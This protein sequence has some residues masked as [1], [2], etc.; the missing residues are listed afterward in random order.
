[1]LHISLLEVLVIH[2][3]M[4]LSTVLSE[5]SLH[6]SLTI[7]GA[8]LGAILADRFGRK[9][10]SFGAIIFVIPRALGIVFNE[11]SVN[12]MLQLFSK[13]NFG[14]TSTLV[15]LYIAEIADT[16]NRKYL[17]TL[18]MPFQYSISIISMAVMIT[19]ENSPR[20]RTLAIL[21]GLVLAIS[22][23]FY[24]ITIVFL[25]ESPDYLY[26]KKKNFKAT[27]SL[28]FFRRVNN[29]RIHEE[30]IELSSLD[31]QQSNVNQHGRFRRIRE[32][33][34]FVNRRSLAIIVSL[35][36]IGW[37]S[38]RIRNRIMYTYLAS[39]IFGDY[40]FAIL[41]G[42]WVVDL[43][44]S[45]FVTLGINA[46]S[47]KLFLLLVLSVNLIAAIIGM[48]NFM[49]YSYVLFGVFLI[50]SV[51]YLFIYGVTQ[52][53]MGEFFPTNIRAFA[54]ATVISCEI[55]TSNI[56]LTIDQYQLGEYLTLE[57]IRLFS[58]INGVIYFCAFLFV[59][60]FF[61]NITQLPS[62]QITVVT[63]TDI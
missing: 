44:F 62:S 8:F 48:L 63:S 58:Y 24:F 47:S 57:Y 56:F 50:H 18:R 9:K 1:M 3:R 10:A 22:V 38:G 34:Q 17:M 33:F 12:R 4:E 61:P 53:Y 32:M 20:E 31:V 29:I 27:K 59:L 30:A 5:F 28:A 45:I 2:S 49:Q 43:I 13:I 37:A 42:I 40:M 21:S 55:L 26:S 16:K 41:L 25:P 54:I 23:L 15:P 46:F 39:L 51:S 52:A 14:M 19:H 36:A 7:L 6:V 60:I 11:S 35:I